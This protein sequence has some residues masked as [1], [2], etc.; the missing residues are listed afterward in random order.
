MGSRAEVTKKEIPKTLSILAALTPGTGGRRGVKF[1]KLTTPLPPNPVA[2][3][4][5]N[6][7]QGYVEEEYLV[8]IQI[9]MLLQNYFSLPYVHE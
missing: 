3:H 6:L 9:M 4:Q 2:N 7:S 8:N 5:C 1:D